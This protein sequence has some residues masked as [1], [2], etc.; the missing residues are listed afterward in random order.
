MPKNTI[1]PLN[2]EI[3]F[4]RLSMRYLLIFLLILSVLM[5]TST[6]QPVQ[7]YCDSLLQQAIQERHQKRFDEAASLMD[8]YLKTCGDSLQYALQL[9]ILNLEKADAEYNGNGKRSKSERLKWFQDGLYFAKIAYEINPKHKLAV[10]YQAL[11]FAGIISVSNLYQQAHLADSVRIYA[12]K[13]LELDDDNDRALH[14]LGRWHYE[15]AGLGWMVRFFSKLFFGIAPQGDYSKSI[16]YFERA[17]ALDDYVVHNYWL[18]MALLKSKQKELAK[19]KFEYVLH[20]PNQQHNDVFLKQQA[21][22]M[23]KKAF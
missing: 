13:M 3:E 14:I 8:S 19:Q 5:E 6:A 21:L 20:L 9:S 16:D 17:V 1:I 15:V 2:P 10:E 11:A 4:L 7:N 23:L 22:I 18:A 12:E